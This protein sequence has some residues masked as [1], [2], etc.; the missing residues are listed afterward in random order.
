MTKRLILATLLAILP[1]IAQT[2]PPPSTV[3]MPTYLGAYANY[4]QS[5]GQRIGFGGM[6]AVP[7]PG[8]VGAAGVYSVTSVDLTL[9]TQV[10]PT[11]GRKFYAAHPSLRTG[12]HK[13]LYTGGKFQILLGGDTDVTGG[14][15]LPLSV[16]VTP[17]YRIN[18]HFGILLPLRARSLK[19]SDSTQAW[20]VIPQVI[21]V[22][23][24]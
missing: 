18:S 1:A 2:A 20:T 22:W 14:Q 21:F 4:C 23:M 11:T 24:P 5:C 9:T 17:A 15:G 19:M 10:D 13:T 7:I 16:T 6:G 12:I 8:A 3:T